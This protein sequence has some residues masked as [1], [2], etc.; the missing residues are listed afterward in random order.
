[1]KS[2]KKGKPAAKKGGWTQSWAKIFLVMA[3]IL[4]VGVMI[5][6]S[7]GTNWLVTMKPANTGDTAVVDLTIRDED[8]RPVLTTNERIYNASFQKGEIVWLTGPLTL[9]VNSTTTEMITPVPVYRQ[10]FGEASFGLFGQE[11][12][13][14]SSSLEG[15]KQGGTQK[16]VFPGS[17]QFQRE[18]D[19]EQFAQIGGN[20]TTALPGDQLLLAFTT[21]PMINVDDNSTPQYAFRTSL[22]TGKDGGNV[23]VNY[24]YPSADIT[25]IRLS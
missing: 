6:T 18:M 20:F 5:I 22:I 12:N 15:M 16:I 14:I 13:Q 24:G 25:I 9:T 3:C 23:T 11:L 17:A 10:D 7:L 2:D 19:P 8:G 4:F 21:T 1:M